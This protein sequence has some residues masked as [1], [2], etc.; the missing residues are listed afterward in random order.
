VTQTD[1]PLAVPAMK[2]L[3]ILLE[4]II[5]YEANHSSVCD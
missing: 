5:D 2:W 3:L 4:D 1:I